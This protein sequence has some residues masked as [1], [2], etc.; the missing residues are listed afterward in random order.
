M[1]SKPRPGTISA[2][3]D[4][5]DPVRT[6][7]LLEVSS[8][9]ARAPPPHVR[10]TSRRAVG[11]DVTLKIETT[12]GHVQRVRGDLVAADGA[13]LTIRTD[14][15]DQPVALDAIESARTVFEWGPAPEARQGI[16]ARPEEGG[17]DG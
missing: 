9:G 2:A 16:S 7:Y 6:R 1:P 4:A 3:L 15:G 11:E 10:R 12:P 5:L 17:C 8:P 13:V 14:T